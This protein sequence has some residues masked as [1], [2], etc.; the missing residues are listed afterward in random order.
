MAKKCS[1]LGMYKDSVLAKQF[2]DPLWVQQKNT[3]SAEECNCEEVA[4]W[5][6]TIKGIPDDVS[7]DLGRNYVNGSALLFMGREYLNE[8]GVTKA[9]PLDLML[10]EIAY[11]CR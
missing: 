6:A 3:V 1:T 9:G 7:P 2:D 11:L 8:I 4:K 10:K 5:G